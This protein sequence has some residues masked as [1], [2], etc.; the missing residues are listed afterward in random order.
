MFYAIL[1]VLPN[2]MKCTFIVFSYS[3]LYSEFHHKIVLAKV[4]PKHW[5]KHLEKPLMYKMVV[6]SIEVFLNAFAK[7][8][9]KLCQNT[10]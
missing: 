5:Q 9:A 10:L 4:L 7:G 3:C 1:Y 8:L 2:K 6:E